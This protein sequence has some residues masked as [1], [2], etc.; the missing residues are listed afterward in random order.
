M[1]AQNLTIDPPNAP[2]A[3]HVVEFQS[4]VGGIMRARGTVLVPVA[5]S[6]ASILLVELPAADALSAQYGL[7]GIWLAYPITFGMMLALQSAFYLTVWR[8]KK[9]APLMRPQH[10]ATYPI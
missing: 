6:V 3:H 10:T 1:R 5:I 8:H 9:N 7:E 4:V 2:A